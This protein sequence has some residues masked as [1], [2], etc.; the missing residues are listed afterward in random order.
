MALLLAVLLG[1]MLVPVAAAKAV[2]SANWAGYVATRANP[3]GFRSV[4][5]TWVIPTISCT[6]EEETA[7]AVWVGLGGFL[8]TAESLE[9]TGTQQSCNINGEATYE[10]WY[11]ILPAPPVPIRIPVSPGD[12]IS[13]STTVRGDAVTFQMHDFSNGEHYEKTRYVPYTD[14]SSAEWI[15]EAP[16]ECPESGRESECTLVPLA[17][18]GTATFER[19][20]ALAGLY[21]RSPGTNIWSTTE[22]TLKQQLGTLPTVYNVERQAAPSGT[23]LTAKPSAP[24]VH[25]GFS[26]SVSERGEEAVIEETPLLP[27]AGRT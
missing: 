17:H 16:S 15:V 4:S 23:T 7:S 19:A 20:T 11:E 26:V 13:A 9:Q 2:I 8:R 27:G 5:G 6:L 10:A 3:L 12:R 22:L 21:R 24:G 14:V 25:G 18:F 1:A